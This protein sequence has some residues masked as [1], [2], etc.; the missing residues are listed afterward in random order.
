MPHLRGRALL[1]PGLL[2]LLLVA[3]AVS[4]D[5]FL[6]IPNL[7]NLSRQSVYLL[8]VALG[9]MV[10][11]LC[12]QLDLSVGATV[13]LSSVITAMT[14]K[15]L[16]DASPLTSIVVAVAAGLA[17]GVAVGLFNGVV[18]AVLRAPAFMV[19][20]G[21]TS[22]AGACALLLTNGV[23]VSGL[24]EAFTGSLGTGRLFGIP[25]PI[26]VAALV[27]LLLYVF[28]SWTVAGRSMYAVGGNA[29]AARAA[30]I[31]TSGTTLAAFVLCSV[32]SALA[33]V[34]LAARVGSGE[35]SLGT[36]YVL[37]S[38]AAA[39]LGGTSLFGGEG[40]VGYVVLGVLFIAVLNNGMNLLRIPSYL[41]ELALGVVLIAAVLGETAREVRRT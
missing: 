35:A 25:V 9:Q 4:T 13:A 21:T 17:T 41:Q 18:V 29:A 8:L 39:V 40:R 33:G 32:L 23:P 24:A 10:V 26:L 2:L 20:L 5:K 30:G 19:T 16:A 12:G 11:L 3:F 36:T 34:L 27:A 1:L 31:R 15:S 22:I 28:L 37:L 38:I 7:T 6:T 14:L